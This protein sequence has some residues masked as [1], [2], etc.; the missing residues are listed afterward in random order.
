MLNK[1]LSYAFLI[2]IG[3]LTLG[4]AVLLF[5]IGLV[6]LWYFIIIFLVIY[7]VRRLYYFFKGE[8]PPT[9]MQQ[10][11]AYYYKSNPQA[12]KKKGRTI[13]YDEFKDK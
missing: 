11:Y 3:I 13:D 4:F 8:K 9:M 6:A 10:Y 2:F 12:P 5:S 7:V 1:I